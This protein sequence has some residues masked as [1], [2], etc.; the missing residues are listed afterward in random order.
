MKEGKEE[1]KAYGLVRGWVFPSR[2]VWF[3][4]KAPLSG[5]LVAILRP[6]YFLPSCLCL[7]RLPEGPPTAEPTVTACQF[8]CSDLK[9]NKYIQE[10]LA[11]WGSKLYL[12]LV[13]S[14]CPSILDG[15]QT[16]GAHPVAR[17]GGTTSVK[18]F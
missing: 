5:T 12:S 4:P 15:L 18:V 6:A 11:E 14:I 7:R 16:T 17:A 10:A 8:M 1:G 3:A 13:P 2:L 9:A